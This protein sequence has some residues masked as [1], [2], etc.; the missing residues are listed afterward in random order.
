[1]NPYD[2]DEEAW[3]PSTISTIEVDDGFYPCIAGCGLYTST[4]PRSKPYWFDTA[5]P[6]AKASDLGARCMWDDP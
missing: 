4:R 3:F 1:M 6:T 2:F 5:T